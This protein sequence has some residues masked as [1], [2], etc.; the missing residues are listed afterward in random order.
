MRVRSSSVAGWPG[1][2]RAAASL[3]MRRSIAKHARAAILVPASGGSGWR[4]HAS[5]DVGCVRAGG[6]GYPRARAAA[7]GGRAGRTGRRPSIE[8]RRARRVGPRQRRPARGGCRGRRLHDAL[9]LGVRRRTASGTPARCAGLRQRVVPRPVPRRRGPRGDQHGAA[10]RRDEH[11][12]RGCRS[13]RGRLHRGLRRAR[14]RPAR[15]AG[16]VPWRA[17][18][19]GGTGRARPAALRRRGDHVP[20]PPGAPRRQRG[21]LALARLDPQFASNGHVWAYY[22][23]EGGER[24]TRLSRFTVEGAAASASSELVVLEVAQ[25]YSNH[26]GGAVRFG[27]DGML[28]L[29]L[30]DGGSGGDPHGNGQDREALLGSVLRLD[31]RNATAAQPYVVP[32]DNPYASGGGRG[33]LWAYG[34]RNPWRMAFD[35]ATGDLWAGDVGQGAVEEIDVV[36]RGGNFG[37][38][39]LEGNRCYQSGCS[40]SGTVLPVA[41]YTHDEGCSVTG[42]VIARG[43]GVPEVEGA[44]LFADY[45][46]G[47]VWAMT[48]ASRGDAVEIGRVDGS[49]TSFTIDSSGRVYIVQSGG[50][51]LRIVSP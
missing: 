38:N 12:G 39:R 48:A 31:V 4:N 21:G 2:I 28:Y 14:L 7:A 44:Y 20:R 5:A 43:S 41:T 8:R 15:G 11:A 26:N 32:S 10:L 36:T 49:P 30:G 18:S 16:A 13:A 34:F 6:G 9:G 45:C 19:A 1:R 27:P 40:T 3:A 46:S 42:G 33:E 25:P 47:R 50:P 23:V 35:D 22:S 24:R 17:L 51:V 29:G 37:W